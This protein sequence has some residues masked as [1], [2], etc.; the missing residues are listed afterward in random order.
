MKDS[1][2]LSTT[3]ILITNEGMGKADL[4][5]QTKLVGTYLKLLIENNYLP[6]AICFYTDGVK[7]VVN[8]SP[9]LDQL[10]QLEQK[11]VRL[12]ICSTCLNYFGLIDKVQ[13]GIMGG[14]LDIVEAQAFDIFIESTE[15]TSR[16]VSELRPKIE[17]PDVIIR[18]K[19]G[20][21]KLLN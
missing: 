13:V 4:E 1:N 10:Q 17:K 14:M 3:V 12:I 5:L 16:M 21:Y 19:V 6:N 2:P 9:V 18:P 8:G 20:Q 15:I 11:G 7:L